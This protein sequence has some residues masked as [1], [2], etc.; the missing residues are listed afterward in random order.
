M[1]RDRVAP[2]RRKVSTKAKTKAAAG[3][4]SWRPIFGVFAL[5]IGA[6]TIFGIIF[7]LTT[8][9]FDGAKGGIGGAVLFSGV[10]ISIGIKWLRG[11]TAE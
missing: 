2:R 4:L 6:L 3:G 9:G 8:K 11:E 1:S 10:M 5:L 7:Q